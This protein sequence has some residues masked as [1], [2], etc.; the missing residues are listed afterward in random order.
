MH[1]IGWTYLGS[2][3]WLSFDTPAANSSANLLLI[4]RALFLRIAF[5]VLFAILVVYKEHPNSHSDDEEQDPI[6]RRTI[7][8]G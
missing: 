1:L 8:S 3:S 2:I 7:E 5:A 4:L 6:A